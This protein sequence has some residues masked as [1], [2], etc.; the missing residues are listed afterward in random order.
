MAVAGWWVVEAGPIRVAAWDLDGGAGF[1]LYCTRCVGGRP[2][3][4]WDESRPL[5]EVLAKVN[6][7]VCT[8]EEKP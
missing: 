4:E 2:F 5:P 8:P 7:H 3:A 6:G 1:G